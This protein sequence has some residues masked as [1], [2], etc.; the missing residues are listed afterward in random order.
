MLVNSVLYSEN[1]KYMIVRH[2][3]RK[4]ET[5]IIFYESFNSVFEIQFY[6]GKLEELFIDTRHFIVY[7]ISTVKFS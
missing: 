5:R 1:E 4:I 2:E 7:V 3:F 6:L